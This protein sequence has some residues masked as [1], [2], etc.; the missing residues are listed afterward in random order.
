MGGGQALTIGLGNRSLFGWVGAF[1]SAVP[2]GDKL[3]KLLAEPKSLNEEL[4]LLWVGCGKQDFLFEANRTFLERL[5]ADKI[6]HVAHISEGAHEW[7]VWRR[8]LNELVPQLFK[9][10]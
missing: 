6:E 10:K 7:R 2:R 5:E 8:Y 1:S 3:D 4:A 9:K